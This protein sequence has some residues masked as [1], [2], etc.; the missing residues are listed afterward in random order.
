MLEIERPEMTER[1]KI[2][3]EYG[4]AALSSISAERRWELLTQA[5]RRLESATDQEA[6]A[7]SFMERC[8][9]AA[10]TGVCASPG[11]NYDFQ[12]NRQAACRIIDIA[13][14]VVRELAVFRSSELK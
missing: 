4:R 8:V 10:L 11:E 7:E 2:C 14:H 1:D 5:V 6:D 9:L 13:A 12:N 3:L